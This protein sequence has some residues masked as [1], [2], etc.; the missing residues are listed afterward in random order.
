MNEP[1][2]QSIGDYNGLKGEKKRVVRVV[3]LSGLL[4]GALYV[5]VSNSYVG[6]VHDR[7]PVHD[8]IA[9]VPFNR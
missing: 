3:L 1:T 4:L 9:A 7:L 5:I 6:E 8:G 2:L